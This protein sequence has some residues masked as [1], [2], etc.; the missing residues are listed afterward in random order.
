MTYK[1]DKKNLKGSYTLSNLLLLVGFFALVV[2]GSS[3][4]PQK[5]KE[6]LY[7]EKVIAESA[8]M[9]SRYDSDDGTSYY[10]KYIYYVNGVEYEHN[11]SGVNS[12]DKYDSIL[13]YKEGSP[14]FSIS[15][16][17]IEQAN[18]RIWLLIIPLAILLAACI[19]RIVNYSKVAKVKKLCKRGILV[20]NIPYKLVSTNLEVNGNQIMAFCIT[21]TFPDGISREL[22][23]NG[24]YKQVDNTGW[25]DML[26]DPDDYSN[27]YIDKSIRVTG[28]GSPV[29]IHY[30]QQ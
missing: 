9:H 25:C 1:I 11:T 26:F 20:K 10:I 7:T 6:K 2:I 28:H 17:E 22:V 4:I 27:Y 18:E 14:S 8:T 30:Q 29:I 23:S 12:D 3:F 5:I 13:Y 15:A 21:Y 24:I 19:V 16:F